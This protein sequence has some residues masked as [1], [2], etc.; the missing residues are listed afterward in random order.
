MVLFVSPAAMICK[1]AMFPA[2]VNSEVTV[3]ACHSRMNNEHS[4]VTLSVLKKLDSGVCNDAN[5]MN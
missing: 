4:N 3:T 2:T 1:V 5:K